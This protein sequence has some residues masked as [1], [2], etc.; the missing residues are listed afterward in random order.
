VW[1]AILQT[2][3][4]AWMRATAERSLMQLKALDQMEAIQSRLDA[5]ARQSGAAPEDWTIAVRAGVVPGVP[6]DPSG[7][8]NELTPSGQIRLSGSSK[9][10]PLPAE[11]ERSAPSR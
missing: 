11:P 4:V 5:F 8:R 7:T 2:S 3:E 10:F 1:T 6:V 9:L